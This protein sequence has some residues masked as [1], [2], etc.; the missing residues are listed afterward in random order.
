MSWE[1]HKPGSVYW[2][3]SLMVILRDGLRGGAHPVGFAVIGG[4]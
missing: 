2:Q 3:Q 1:A 4:G